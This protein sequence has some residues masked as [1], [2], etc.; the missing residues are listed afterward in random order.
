[1]SSYT[2]TSAKLERALSTLNKARQ[3]YQ[4]T[5]GQRISFTLLNVAVYSVGVTFGIALLASVLAGFDMSDGVTGFFDSAA[6]FSV[7]ILFTFGTAI[8]AVIAVLLT[9]NF[10]LI[11]KFFRLNKLIHTLGLADIFEAPWRAARD[12]KWLRN[13]LTFILGPLIIIGSAPLAVAYA[14]PAEEDLF[15]VSGFVAGIAFMAMHLLRR[16]KEKID[17]VARLQD[18]FERYRDQAAE[19]E[20]KHV[21]IPEA[22]YD[23]FARVERAQILRERARSI[24][25]SYEE[26][27]NETYMVQKSRAVR[28][29]K[30]DFDAAINLSIQNQIDA[31]TTNPRPEGVT[32]DADSGIL[33]VPVPKTPVA[34]RF[35]VDDK[36][37]RIEILSLEHDDAPPA[38]SDR[39]EGKHG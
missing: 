2:L 36:L 4:L 19:E 15:M 28:A 21:E 10:R 29:S 23:Q 13:F 5:R 22:V 16:I 6:D 27:S 34:L 25:A 7:F 1:M 14:F 33:R 26:S 18:T 35:K 32:E 30:A 11:L 3:G 24:Q 31:L 39:E 17:V 8:I 9:F 20:T 37:R 38:A 12:K